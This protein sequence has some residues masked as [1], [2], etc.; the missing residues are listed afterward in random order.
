MV[1]PTQ[2]HPLYLENM[3]ENYAPRVTS[4]LLDLNKLYLAQEVITTL[5]KDLSQEKNANFAPQERTTIFK[6]P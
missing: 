3:L 1:R 5:T 6:E 2:L 4:V